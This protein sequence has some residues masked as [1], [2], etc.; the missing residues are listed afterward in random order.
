MEKKINKS[1]RGNKPT[2]R[3]NGYVAPVG[4]TTHTERWGE[5]VCGHLY[6]FFS[7]FP[8]IFYNQFL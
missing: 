7:L 2:S 4:H 6:Q 1:M 8:R 3:K 5:L